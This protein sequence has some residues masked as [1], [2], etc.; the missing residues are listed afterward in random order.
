MT[1]EE[2]ALKVQR[3]DDRS[4]SNAPRLD[5]VEKKLADNDEMLASIARL[6]QRQKDMDTD[7]KEIKADVKAL[8]GKP[9]KRWECI[10]DKALMAVVTALVGYIFI[11]LG[12]GA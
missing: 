5:E 8:A 2:L 3:A 11:R 9:A 4:K 12:F 1:T 10:V 6:D 7:V